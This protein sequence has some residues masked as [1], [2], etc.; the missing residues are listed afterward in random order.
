MTEKKVK[1]GILG[2]GKIA[3]KFAEAAG[4]VQEA[5]VVAVAS[6]SLERAQ[7]FA[8][9]YNIKLALDSYDALM[10]SNEIDAIYIATPHSIHH[11]YTLACLRHKKAVLCEKALAINLR[12]V[13]EMVNV[14]RQE[15]VFLMEAMWTR[16]LP[17]FNRVLEIVKSGELGAIKSIQTDFGFKAPIDHSN[18]LYNLALGGGSL[19]DVGIYPV[20]LVSYL[21]GKPKNILASAAFAETGADTQC[22]FIFEYD[23]GVQATITSSIVTDTS[24]STQINFEKGRV[25]MCRP[26]YQPSGIK[27]YTN[28]FNYG[29]EDYKVSGQN[30]YEYEIAAASKDILQGKIE[31]VSMPHSSSLLLMECLDTIREKI[32]LKYPG[33]DL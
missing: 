17:S 19:L 18:R 13:T 9:S 7:Q 27:V 2:P 20:F 29:Y 33:H 10:Q 22:S 14:A 24:I 28:R 21:L 26:W 3:R 5:E 4:R 30:G 11:K 12:E 31:N 32:G 23:Q 15:Q 6:R 25:E 16:F 1:W 8:S